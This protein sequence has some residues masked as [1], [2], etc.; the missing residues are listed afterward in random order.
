MIEQARL[1][2]LKAAYMMD[3]VGNKVAKAEIAM[4]KIVAPQMACQIIDWAIQ[5][6]GDMYDA[7]KG[8]AYDGEGGALVTGRFMG[9]ASFGVVP[10]I[11]RGNSDAFVMH[12]TA[13]GDVLW[14]IHVGGTSSDEGVGITHDGAGGALVTGSF[15]DTARFGDM[16]FTSQGGSDIFVMHVK[17]TQQIDWVAQAG[18]EFDDGGV[19]IVHGG[20]GSA[21]VTGFTNYNVDL[22]VSEIFV[23][24]V[25]GLASAMWPRTREGS[26]EMIASAGAASGS[27]GITAGGISYR[28]MNQSA[29]VT[30][31]FYG[32]LTF[33]SKTVTGNRVDAAHAFAASILPFEV[34]PPPPPSILPSEVPTP[35]PPS[36]PVFHAASFDMHLKPAVVGLIS[37][38]CGFLALLSLLLACLRCRRYRRLFENLRISRDRAQIDLHMLEHRLHQE[39]QFAHTR[40]KSP[41]YATWSRCRAPAPR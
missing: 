14:A 31:T 11:S 12:V 5:A 17:A 6:G 18:G 32:N 28:P 1:L 38:I 35:P 23:A 34:P 15:L 20:A 41:I 21:L 26:F 33:G 2:T 7:G 4:I 36:A 24:N 8:I 16:L 25:A 27:H 19:G 3:T 39:T 22:G 40:P 10:L 37:S 9:D 29:L 30:G 13:S